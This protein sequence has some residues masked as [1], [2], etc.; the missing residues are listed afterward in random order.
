MTASDP[1]LSGRAAKSLGGGDIAWLVGLAFAIPTYC[2]VARWRLRGK[3][4]GT[5]GLAVS[6]HAS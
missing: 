4:G 5:A 1:P 2:L 3:N 6:Q